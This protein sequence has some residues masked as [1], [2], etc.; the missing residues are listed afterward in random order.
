MPAENTSDSTLIERV[1]AVGHAHRTS[2]SPRRA[3]GDDDA[4][5]PPRADSTTASIRNCS[6]TS[7]SS[8]P[9]ARRR[10]ISRV[11]SVTLTS[12]MFMMPMP[13]TSRLTAATAPSRSVSTP[14]V[15]DSVSA[16]CWV[17]KMLKLSSSS[18]ASL[19]RSRSSCRRLAF[20]GTLSLPS[21]IDTSAC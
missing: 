14:M 4:D 16:S 2:E 7:P 18:S 11:R 12:M 13:P 5:T 8:A 3:G 20:S 21:C 6:S 19:R 15:L 17:S 1:E 9:T 10:P